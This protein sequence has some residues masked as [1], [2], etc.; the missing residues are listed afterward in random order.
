MSWADQ[1]IVFE[2][3]IH[4]LQLDRDLRSTHFSEQLLNHLLGCTEVAAMVYMVSELR[5]RVS[6]DLVSAAWELLEWKYEEHPQLLRDDD[7]FCTALAD[8]T[9]QAWE[10]RRPE[11]EAHGDVV[12]EFIRV[13]QC[14]GNAGHE[15]ALT[16][17]IG[18]MVEDG[19]FQFGSMDDDPLD[20][21]YWTE[22][23][24]L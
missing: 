23:P 12:P 21:I 22:L 14:R 5:H 18:T 6:G 1:D 15:E 9:L 10:A 3:S 24:P 2:S 19:G 16:A 11:A 13:L 7:K 20:W 4:L 8:L 17:D